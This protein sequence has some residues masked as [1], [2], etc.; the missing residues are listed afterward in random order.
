M[1]VRCG[2]CGTEYEFDDALV[3]ERGTSV[4]C[5]NC[6]YQFKVHP[7]KAGVGVPERWIVRT[8]AG[9]E[10]VY[11]SLRDLQKAIA[12]RQVGPD[13]LLSRAGRPPRPLASIAELEPFFKAKTGAPSSPPGAAQRTVQGLG[14]DASNYGAPPAPHR[15]P[16]RAPATETPP[17]PVGRPPDEDEDTLQRPAVGRSVPPPKPARRSGAPAVPKKRSRT[18]SGPPPVPKRDKLATTVKDESPPREQRRTE[19][20]G[21]FADMEPEPK[22]IPRNDPPPARAPT[23]KP[24]VAVPSEDVVIRESSASLTPTPSDVRESYRSYEEIHTD[25]R[26]VSGPPPSRRAKSRWIVAVVLIGAVA[27]FA[28][29][30]GREYLARFI[31]PPKAEQTESDS[32][33]AA[34]IKKGN[35][36]LYDGDFEG[37]KEQFDKATALSERDPK[38]LA[39]L[40][41]LHAARADTLWL[42]LRLL[43]PKNDELVKMTHRILAVRVEKADIAARKAAEVAPDDATVVRARVDAY[44]LLGEVS[45][46]RELVAKIS[47]DA[48]DPETAYVLATLDMAE[49]APGWQ[50]V[51]DR[52]RTAVGGERDLGR[53]RS[54]LVYALARS[55]AAA[56]AKAELAKIEALTRPHPLLTELRGFIRRFESVAAD[57]GAD[58]AVEVATVDLSSL[59]VLE[60]TAGDRESF[61]DGFSATPAGDFR[62]LLKQASAAMR[63]GDLDRAESL[64]STVLAKQPGNTEAIS[65][66]GDVA[67]ARN[68]PSAAEKQYDKVLEKNPSFLPALLSKADAKWAQGDKKGAAVLYRRVLEQAGPGSSY[69]QRAA[70]R[71]AEAAKGGTETPPT[72]PIPPKPSTPDPPPDEKKEPEK[73]HI[74]TTDLPEFNQ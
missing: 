24:E 39:A 35:E 60:P 20:A 38:A 27:L 14:T 66:L 72:E 9:R 22:T 29:T 19:P 73:P 63:A 67:K 25:P 64:Y 47:G 46:A 15:V 13:D 3:S 17:M 51:I 59:P 71:L 12:Q 1:D 50:S 23:P 11:T 57:A 68:D 49:K 53:A 69:G 10:L 41:R 16:P 8:L 6:G 74:D 2:R 5:T 70:A 32:R 52:L 43:D 65:G 30:I 18:K 36:L 45:K 4:K 28:A 62:T 7:P 58:A 31:Q 40:A 42:K 34:M 33:V 48:S 61:D 21:S 44:R 37:A 56:D 55:G 54:A 26:F